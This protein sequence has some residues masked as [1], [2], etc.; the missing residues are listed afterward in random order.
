MLLSVVFQS[1]KS[2][3]FECV[4]Q[5]IFPKDNPQVVNSAGVEL[6]P[7]DHVSAWA[8]VAFVVAL[9]LQGD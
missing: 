1:C 9:K 8:A 5:L 7:E 4:I 2:F 6:Y 3:T